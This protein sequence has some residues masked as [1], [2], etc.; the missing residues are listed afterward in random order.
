MFLKEK[1]RRFTLLTTLLTPVGE[2]FFFLT[3]QL[4]NR[5]P[6]VQ[7]SSDADEWRRPQ[8]RRARSLDLPCIG[9]SREGWVTSALLAPRLQT[10]AFPSL[11]LRPSDLLG[12]ITE[13][14]NLDVR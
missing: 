2:D 8:R 6:A 11:P 7:L 10:G 4:S 13:L 14:G 5:G 9:A 12:W 1:T 3:S